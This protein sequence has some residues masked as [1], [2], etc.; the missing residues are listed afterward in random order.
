MASFVNAAGRTAGERALLLPI[1]ARWF[2]RDGPHGK[3]WFVAGGRQIAGVCIAVAQSYG[4]DVGWSHLTVMALLLRAG[5]RG[6]P[7][8]LDR[9]SEERSLC[10]ERVL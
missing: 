4:W 5:R 2:R 10:P 8:R 3:R 7:G 1:A 9:H 6:L